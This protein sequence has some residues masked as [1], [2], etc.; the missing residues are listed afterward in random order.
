MIFS[1]NK[2]FIILL[3][4]SLSASEAAF[5]SNLWK[6]SCSIVPEAENSMDSASGK[7]EKG[8]QKFKNT[9][10]IQITELAHHLKWNG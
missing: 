4:T 3:M 2:L 7:K 5:M 6:C 10:K 1:V 8:K 9:W